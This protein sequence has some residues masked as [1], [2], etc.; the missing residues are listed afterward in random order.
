MYNTKTLIKNAFRVSKV[1]GE[2]AIRLRVP[3]GHLQARYLT[4]VH[5]LAE[6]FGNGT[7]HLTTRQGYEIPGIKLAQLEE[8]KDH[9]AEMIAQIESS[10]GVVL[11]EPA[12][13][14]PSAGTRNISACIGNRVCRFANTDTSALA[15]KIEQVIY[16][17]DYHLK[18]AVTG[19]PNDCIKAH[20]QDIGIIGS[21]VP[22][23]DQ[24]RCILCEACMDNCRKKIT[25]ALYI[26]NYRMIRD[27]EYCLQCGEC[28]LKCPTGAFSR[29]KKVYRI[30]IGG[31]T[32]KRN[33]R[34]ANTF[35]RNASEKTVLEICRN[36]YGFIHRHIDR[37][38][39]KEHLGYIIDR[40][41]FAAFASEVLDQIELSPPEEMVE[42]TNPGYFYPKR[43]QLA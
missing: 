38:L 21:V 3:G 13:G 40:M 28:V 25:N 16:P 11:E 8:V 15:Q 9:M 14:Y 24:D 19:C 37:S 23:Y 2:S 42:L 10:C 34:L 17:N 18:V 1:R 6:K 36:V 20:M 33:P 43:K 5:E 7:V 22:E 4:V 27:E 39:G 12:K 30:I 32:G 26:D 31:R 29:G 41:G 35:I